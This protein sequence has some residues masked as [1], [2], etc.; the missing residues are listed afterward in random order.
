[1]G[2]VPHEGALEQFGTDRAVPA[3][4]DRVHHRGLDAGGDDADVGGMKH[5]VE[6]GGE[7]RAMIA[8]EEREPAGALCEVH[9][10]VVRHLS[11]TL[12]VILVL[13]GAAVF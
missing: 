2:E 8:N 11:L 13:S 1:V 10:C 5:R 12:L 6:G 4:L 7:P 9:Q 3:F